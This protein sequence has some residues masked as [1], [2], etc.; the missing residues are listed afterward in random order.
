MLYTKTFKL[1]VPPIIM[2]SNIFLKNTYSKEQNT[3]ILFQNRL[4]SCLQ[5]T[6]NFR[7]DKLV[8]QIDEQEK[9]DRRKEIP[10]ICFRN[11]K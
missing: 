2:N 1:L 3:E 5:Y 4:G 7:T 11:R 6:T 10:I 9:G 8:L